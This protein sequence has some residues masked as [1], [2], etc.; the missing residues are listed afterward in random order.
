M[1]FGESKQTTL[2]FATVYIVDNLPE[3]YPLMKFAPGSIVEGKTGERFLYVKLICSSKYAG[4]GV[5]TLMLDQLGR[6]DL[7]DQ[8]GGYDGIALSAIAQPYPFYV[9]RGF[10]RSNGDGRVFPADP[11]NTVFRHDGEGY[12]WLLIKYNSDDGAGA[13]PVPSKRQKTMEGGTRLERPIESLSDPAIRRLAQRAGVPSL[14]TTLH[15]AVQDMA[16]AWLTDAIK[17]ILLVTQY[18]RR[19]TVSLADVVEVLRDN[20]GVKTAGLDSVEAATKRV[21]R[22]ISMDLDIINRVRWSS[23]A[24]AAVHLCLEA[25]LMKVLY[26]SFQVAV[27]AERTTVTAKDL[28]CVKNVLSR[29]RKQ[30]ALRIL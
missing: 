24:F 20:D 9:K 23:A 14:S 1:Q 17:R 26:Q 27:H 6:K 8:L 18:M 2:G 11:K 5:A 7:A 12:G 22:A 25:Y 29:R 4:S 3:T 28:Q 30:R 16:E 10:R 21:I 15:T 13:S 19:V